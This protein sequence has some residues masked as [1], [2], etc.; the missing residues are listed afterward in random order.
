VPVRVVGVVCRGCSSSDLI[1]NEAKVVRN[2]K[3]FR[4]SGVEVVV[5]DV[6]F[7]VSVSEKVVKFK[8]NVASV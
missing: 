5:N 6:E 3:S 8:K 2:E 4:F 1:K 7:V